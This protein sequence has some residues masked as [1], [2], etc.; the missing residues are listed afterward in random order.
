MDIEIEPDKTSW[1]TLRRALKD[2]AD[3]REF[4]RDLEVSWRAAATVA[5]NDARRSARMIPAPRSR[6]SVSLRA[7]IASGVKVETSMGVKK[8]GRGRRAGIALAG[9]P[10]VAIVWKRSGMAGATRGKEGRRQSILWRAGWLLNKGRVWK[11]PTF[12][13]APN[14]VT[15]VPQAK[16]WFDDSIEPHLPG[17]TLAVRQAYNQMADRI[18]RRS[19]SR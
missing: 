19:V 2:A 14:V 6:H 17:M 3:G 11:H 1:S 8:V 9:N 18:E 7:A 12:G 15:G 5:A 13:L 16:G 10:S 4:L